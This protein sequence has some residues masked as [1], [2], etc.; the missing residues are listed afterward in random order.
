VS[1]KCV[2]R[3]IKLGKVNQVAAYSSFRQDAA[4]KMT[5]KSDFPSGAPAS[6]CPNASCYRTVRVG[7][8]RHRL[9]SVNE[10]KAAWA[11]S[12]IRRLC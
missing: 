10:A 3:R 7:W 2:F 11:L 9:S 8:S 6:T 4:H 5:A 1:A 12:V